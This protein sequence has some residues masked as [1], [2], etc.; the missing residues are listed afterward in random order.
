MLMYLKEQI[1]KQYKIFKNNLMK[2]Q[3]FNI[4]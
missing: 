2:F 4:K 3:K 1:Y